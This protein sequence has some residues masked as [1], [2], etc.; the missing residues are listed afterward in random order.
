MPRREVYPPYEHQ[1]TRSGCWAAVAALAGAGWC[2]AILKPSLVWLALFL[3]APAGFTI[4]NALRE[5]EVTRRARKRRAMGIKGLLVYS[6]SPNWQPY[7]EDQW[8]PRVAGRL[9]LLDWSDRKRWR[10]HDYRVRLYNT[11]LASDED[12]NPAAVIFSESGVAL[13][14]RFYPA[15]KN[16]KH[17]NTDGLKNLEARFFAALEE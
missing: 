9:D 14:F 2:V 7:I 5:W 12:Y 8:I 13:V 16:A 11:F 1:N 15:F 4:W 6:R 10:E 3:N 17:G